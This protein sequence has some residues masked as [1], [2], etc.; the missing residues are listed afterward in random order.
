MLRPIL[1]ST[2]HLW[3]TPVKQVIL[4]V[5]LVRTEIIYSVCCNQIINVIEIQ[6]VVL[7]IKHSKELT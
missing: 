1:Y 6:P 5:E 4:M 7:D 3:Q 2:N